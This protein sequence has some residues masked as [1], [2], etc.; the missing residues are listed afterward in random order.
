MSRAVREPCHLSRKMNFKKKNYRGASLKPKR[1]IYKI[2]ESTAYCLKS[3]E[4]SI[5]LNY[6][7]V[8]ITKLTNQHSFIMLY[9]CIIHMYETEKVQNAARE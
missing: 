4:V 5:K 6:K 1:L 8:D 9:G 2:W 3:F 7:Q